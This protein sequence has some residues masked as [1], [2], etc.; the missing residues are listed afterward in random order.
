MTCAASTSP[1]SPSTAGSASASSAL[2][3]WTACCTANPGFLLPPH[4]SH[5]PPTFCL[6]LID[7]RPFWQN[8]GGI[9]AS[10]RI[11]RD[12]CGA[13]GKIS[14]DAA[15]LSQHACGCFCPC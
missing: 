11:N 2:S 8:K 5:A 6:F 4:G 1:S 13:N 10:N 12:D 7:R 14:L 3:C 15:L 9:G